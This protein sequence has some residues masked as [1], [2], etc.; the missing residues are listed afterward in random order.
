MKNKQFKI[1]ALS[2]IVL[3]I[4]LSLGAV[5][6]SDDDTSSTSDIRLTEGFVFT[7]F[8]PGNSSRI[9]EYLPQLPSGTADL[10]NGI[11]LEFFQSWFCF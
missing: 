10:N 1:K 11:T 4:V 6:C 5:S 9:V 8:T 2:L 3:M 7:A